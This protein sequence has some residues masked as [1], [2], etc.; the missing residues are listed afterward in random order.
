MLKNL[1]FSKDFVELNNKSKP[2]FEKYYVLC[3]TK[4]SLLLHLISSPQ[5]SVGQQTFIQIT[6]SHFFNLLKHLFLILL[7]TTHLVIVVE[8]VAFLIVTPLGIAETPRVDIHIHVPTLVKDTVT[9]QDNQILTRI[10][11]DLIKILKNLLKTHVHPS[12]SI[13]LTVHIDVMDVL[14]SVHLVIIVFF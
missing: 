11:L 3:V 9:D 12:D 6:S 10:D 4:K 5:F 2:Q 8:A 7:I 1:L 14:V 13:P